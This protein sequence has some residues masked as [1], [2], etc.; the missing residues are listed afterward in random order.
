MRRSVASTPSLCSR[1]LPGRLADIFVDVVAEKQHEVGIL[2]GQMAIG[3]EI[4]VF[5]IGAGDEAEAQPV[6]RR[7]GAGAVRSA[8]D[9]ARLAAGDEAIPVLPARFEAAA[10]DMHRMREIRLGLVGAAPHDLPHAASSA[11]TSQ[12]T[13]TV[14]GGMPPGRSGSGDSGSGAS[15]VHSTDPVRAADSPRRRRARTD[16]RAACPRGA[17]RGWR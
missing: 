14:A 1:T 15:R 13:G 3:G 4:A 16:R 17:G 8:A 2:V 12:S 10:L 11:A 6:E 7:A 5:V 9:R